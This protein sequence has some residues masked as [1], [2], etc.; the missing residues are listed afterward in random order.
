MITCTLTPRTY[1]Q[2][3]VDNCFNLFNAG[4]TGVL[5]RAFTGSGKTPMACLCME[6][7]LNMGA[8]RKCMVISYEKQLVWQFSQEIEDFL[9]ITPAVEMGTQHAADDTH[10]SSS[11]LV[12]HC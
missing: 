4:T 6:R 11:S 2:E 5:I 8:N 9:D 7:W 1:Q 3:A 10:P 12:S